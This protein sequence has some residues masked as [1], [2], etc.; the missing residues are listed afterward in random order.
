MQARVSD[1][2]VAHA[3]TV[4][5][6]SSLWTFVTAVAAATVIAIIVII[7]VI[8]SEQAAHNPITVTIIV[9]A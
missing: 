3:A 6:S 9:V 2:L 4:N 1:E 5:H 8:R 7:V